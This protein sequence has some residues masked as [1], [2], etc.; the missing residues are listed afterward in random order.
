MKPTVF[1]SY[2]QSSADDLSNHI[3]EALSDVA[4]VRRDKESIANWGSISKF[5][6]SIRDDDFVVMIVTE[7]YLKSSGCMYEVSQLM[8]EKNWLD[9]VMFVVDVDD[10]YDATSETKYI[11]YWQKREE[12][13]NDDV[14]QI[15]EINLI[16]NYVRELKKINEFKSKITEFI[17]SIRDRKNPKLDEA[18]E[19][20]RARIE[21]ANHD[22]NNLNLSNKLKSSELIR[23]NL[24]IPTNQRFMKIFGEFMNEELIEATRSQTIRKYSEGLVDLFLRKMIIRQLNLVSP[25]AYASLSWDEKIKVI[26]D[27][28]SAEFANKLKKITEVSNKAEDFWKDISK[29]EF[30][31][32]V[33]IANRLVDDIFVEYFCS[34]E[35]TF[36]KENIYCYF[37]M[38]PL[39]NRI[40]ILENVYKRVKNKDVVDRLSLAYFK[41]GEREKAEKILKKAVQ[42]GLINYAFMEGQKEKFDALSQEL[43]NVQE[44]NRNMEL[45]NGKVY[46]I[47]HG[48]QLVVGF[49]SSNDIFDVEKVYNIM[50]HYEKD[51]REQY[52]EFMDMLFMLLS[53]DIREY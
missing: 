28:Y 37:S 30:E 39:Q 44:K 34:D 50:R 3:R 36:G 27:S 4:I 26:S 17:A 52:P 31:R 6:E 1:I 14:K 2:N 43:K 19:A 46:G 10:I 23:D 18:V 32:I 12:E 51:I 47:W 20:I 33:N 40:Y 48:K 7:E 13:I 42:E 15:N 24:L 9:K 16:E 11:L 25:D 22:K 35:H 49:P 8:R 38:L 45:L 41:N 29:E 53:K 21:E 5:M